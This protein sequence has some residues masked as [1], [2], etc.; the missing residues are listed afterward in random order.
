MQ[1]VSIFN[2]ELLR[3]G[4]KKQ[5][6]EETAGWWKKGVPED[7]R[8]EIGKI[9][10]SD[11]EERDYEFYFTLKNCKEI[12]ETKDWALFKPY[13]GFKTRGSKKIEQ[14]SWF[15]DLE[16]IE[17][18]INSKSRITQDE[19][20]KLEEIRVIFEKKLSDLELL[21]EQNIDINTIDE[22]SQ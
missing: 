16:R 12:I 7:V 14:I 11:E 10:E 5:Y 8:I 4:I 22:N 3:L 9:K 20:D 6:G 19:F 13:F 18:L 17:K 2:T 21:S 15:N 1:I